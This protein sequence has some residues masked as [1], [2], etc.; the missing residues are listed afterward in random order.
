M[1]LFSREN[2]GLENHISRIT[3][4]FKVHSFHRSYYKMYLMPSLRRIRIQIYD[5]E[6]I[7]DFHLSWYDA[8]IVRVLEEGTCGIPGNAIS[9]LCDS[10][11]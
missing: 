5:R 9:F 11:I 7:D 4:R 6:D 3:Q 10:T 2:E 8:D 1:Y